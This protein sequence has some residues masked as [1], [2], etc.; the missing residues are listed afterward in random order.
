MTALE[1]PRCRARNDESSRRC[2]I[3]TLVLRNDLP[4]QPRGLSALRDGDRQVWVPG[5]GLIHAMRANHGTAGAAGG[6]AAVVA[7]AVEP[8][9]EPEG[10]SSGGARLW[11]PTSVVDDVEASAIAAIVVDAPPHTR[12][13]PAP[14]LSSDVHF[15]P[16]LLFEEW[17]LSD[18]ELDR[19]LARL[20]LRDHL[21]S[22][23]SHG[24]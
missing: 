24:C 17:L 6:P 8:P 3:C 16:D 1:C 15:D 18:E 22:Q 19:S 7:P 20:V 4:D 11:E 23:E 14:S 10:A 9:A 21:Q 12:P 5:E 13:T 2:R